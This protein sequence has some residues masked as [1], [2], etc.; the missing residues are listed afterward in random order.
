MDY[1]GTNV[2]NLIINVDYPGIIVEYSGMNVKY[3]YLNVEI[4]GTTDIGKYGNK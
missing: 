2:E 4:P 1:P 3:M